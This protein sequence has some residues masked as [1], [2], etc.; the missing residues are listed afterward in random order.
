MLEWCVVDW[1]IS[2]LPI[3][4]GRQC[5]K[6]LQVGKVHERELAAEVEFVFS[7]VVTA[8]ILNVRISLVD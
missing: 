1:G 7:V 4:I 5:V 8:W 3:D 6:R 2:R